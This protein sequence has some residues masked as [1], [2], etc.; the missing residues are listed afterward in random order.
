MEG[1]PWRGYGNA[2]A[3]VEWNG[4]DMN[5]HYGSTCGFRGMDLN[6]G[7]DTRLR[8][9]IT[10]MC[11]LFTNV[12]MVCGRKVHAGDG[13]DMNWQDTKCLGSEHEDDGQDQDPRSST[14]ENPKKSIRKGR[15]GLRK[16]AAD[17]MLGRGLPGQWRMV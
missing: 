17:R 8:A 9:N 12:M 2:E 15:I 10:E 13:D 7:Q 11:W 3:H 5:P 16:A 14:T 4:M 1:V 6:P